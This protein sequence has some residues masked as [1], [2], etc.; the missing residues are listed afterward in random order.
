[1]SGRLREQAEIFS[2]ELLSTIEPS[3]LRTV[4]GFLGQRFHANRET[5]LKDKMLAEGFIRLHERK[6][7]TI[8]HWTKSYDDWFWLGEQIGKWLD[9]S[10]YAALI[11]LHHCGDGEEGLWRGHRP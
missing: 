1:V 8:F 4:G 3:A 11:Q 9:A 7:T 5:R 10:T 6:T 2:H